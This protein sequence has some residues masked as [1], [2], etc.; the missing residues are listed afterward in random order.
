MIWPKFFF[1]L[2]IMQAILEVRIEI[3][4]AVGEEDGV[5]RWLE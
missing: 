4:A 1:L 5:T 3:L 2:N